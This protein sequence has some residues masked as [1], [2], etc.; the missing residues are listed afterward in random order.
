MYIRT[1]KGWTKIY[2]SNTDQNKSELAMLVLHKANL[3]IR[4][5]IEDKEVH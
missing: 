3:Q 1:A 2:Y 4:K 5:I